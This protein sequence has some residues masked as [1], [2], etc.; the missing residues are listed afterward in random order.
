[1]MWPNSGCCCG[2]CRT[3][4]VNALKAHGGMPGYE[5]PFIGTWVSTGTT[6]LDDVALMESLTINIAER[7]AWPSWSTQYGCGETRYLQL[8]V[9]GTATY[10]ED[11][12]GGP[13]RYTATWNA[14][15]KW[16]R[17]TGFVTHAVFYCDRGQG[18][19]VELVYELT[20]NES[21]GTYT[22]VD[23][24]ATASTPYVLTATDTGFVGSSAS[25]QITESS[26]TYDYTFVD[27]GHGLGPDYQTMIYTLSDQYSTP[28]AF[29]EAEEMADLLDLT[30]LATG[31]STGTY[32]PMNW[33]REYNVAYSGWPNVI[34]VSEWDTCAGVAFAPYI[35][36]LYGEVSDISAALAGTDIASSPS[37]LPGRS[38]NMPAPP[39]DPTGGP[40]LGN[41]FFCI[42]VPN[43]K[44]VYVSKFRA[45]PDG[46]SACLW[47][48]EQQICECGPSEGSPFTFDCD[49]LNYKLTGTQDCSPTFIAAGDP[50]IYM[51]PGDVFFALGI[52]IL[53]PTC[54]TGCPATNTPPDCCTP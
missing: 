44:W 16:S 35:S 46:G 40:S 6:G 28:D 36:K 3:I 14:E 25:I 34:T 19:G 12:G 15:L 1:M 31:D 17:V 24:T 45:D 54:L 51:V 42:Y 52:S 21:T 50:E 22:L 47:S 23:N 39:S 30:D 4:Q 38:M 8:N 26:A 13:V 2:D 20:L 18:G 48:L 53:Y 37:G 49:P 41:L 43:R 29:G 10:V 27:S 9:S 5:P 33:N 7:N 11:P 32:V